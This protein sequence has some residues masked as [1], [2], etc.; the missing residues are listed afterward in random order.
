[1]V[2]EYKEAAW[3]LVLLLCNVRGS[4]RGEKTTF[5]FWHVRGSNQG[6]LE[7]CTRL[8]Q[9]DQD[10]IFL[11]H[12]LTGHKRVVSTMV[13]G[14]FGGIYPYPSQKTGT[15]SDDFFDMNM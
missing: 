14:P 3:K 4:N 5:L 9:V 8:C 12:N 10:A 2:L 6:P 13:C 11:A 7:L 15:V 1:M